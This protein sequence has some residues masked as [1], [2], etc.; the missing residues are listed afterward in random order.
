MAVD[1]LDIST[2]RGYSV[3]KSNKIIQDIIKRKRELKAQEQKAISYIISMI[4]EGDIKKPSHIYIFDLK[5][6]CDVCGISN[7]SGRNNEAIKET[8]EGI[9]SNGF[10][11]STYDVKLKKPKNTYFQWITTPEIIDNQR[12][13]V[14]IPNA[15]FEYLDGMKSY[16]TKYE[17]Y[18]ILALKSAYSIVLYEL[19]KSYEFRTVVEIPLDELRRNLGIDNDETEKGKEKYSDFKDFKKRVLNIAKE[20]INRY[21]DIEIDWEGI[22]EGRFYKKIRFTVL[23]KEDAERKKATLNSINAINHS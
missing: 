1:F 17:L 4:Q 18:Q 14:Q 16:F 22:R 13:R 6:F 21:T 23:T 7:N 12:I 11:I 15:I 3:I 2:K 10:W 20:E 8:L 9:A 19:L 5:I